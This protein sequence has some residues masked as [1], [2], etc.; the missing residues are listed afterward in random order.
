MSLIVETGQAGSDSESYA[1]VA[2]ADLYFSN[3]ANAAWAA[4][5]TPTKEAYLRLASEYMQGTYRLRWAGYRVSHTQA[6]DWPRYLVPIK[7]SPGV[8]GS[9]PA[10]YDY[11]SV[12]TEVQ[13]ACIML[14]VKVAA[15]ELAP[16]VQPPVIHEGVGPIS[17]G[18]ANGARQTVRYQAI[19]HLLDPL[20]ATGESNARI[21]RA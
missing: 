16:D 7:D 18:Y 5:D 19:D 21:T 3:R 9:L 11:K 17:V 1:T 2:Q 8:Y 6:L 20:L 13:T 4:L 15:G 10:Y 14:A 12:P